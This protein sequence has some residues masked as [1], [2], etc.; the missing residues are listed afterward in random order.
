MITIKDYSF[1]IDGFLKSNFD[2][3]INDAIPNEWDAVFIIF[4]KEG[5][6]KSTFASQSCLYLDHNFK[7]DHVV[8]KPEDFEKAVDDARNGSSIM[9]DEAITGANAQQHATNIQIK[10]IM[11]LTQIRKKKLKIFVLF[12]YLYMMTKYFISRCMGSMYIYAKDFNDRGYGLFYNQPQTEYLYQLMKLKYKFSY[13]KAIKESNHSFPF[14]FPKTLCLS[15]KDYEK[16]KDLAQ[17]SMGAVGDLW[18]DRCGEMARWMNKKYDVTH[19]Q[20]AK[21]WGVTQQTVSATITKQTD[22]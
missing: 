2:I 18:K 5:G 9:W 15:K 22:I 21:I 8:Y 7:L 20:I 13:L 6:G 10:I 4:G 1:W 11:K 19:K 12:P 3:V 16:K 14:R 17:K